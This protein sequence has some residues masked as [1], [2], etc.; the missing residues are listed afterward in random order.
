MLGVAVLHLIVLTCRFYGRRNMAFNPCPPHIAFQGG[1]ELL[2]VPQDLGGERGSQ[3]AEG[4]G[5]GA[6]TGQ[7]RLDRCL[8]SLAL[9]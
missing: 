1:R 2:T 8:V 5:G 4:G 7:E 9:L 6:G 3:T